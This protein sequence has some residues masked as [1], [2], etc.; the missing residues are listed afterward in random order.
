MPSDG[1][2]GEPLLAEDVLEV[3]KVIP[4]HVEGGPY[5]LVSEEAALRLLPA[6][7]SHVQCR[8][9]ARTRKP[10][11]GC[12]NGGVPDT[13]AAN[14]IDTLRVAEDGS[15]KTCFF[16]CD[17]VLHHPCDG[18]QVRAIQPAHIHHLQFPRIRNPVGVSSFDIK[19][20]RLT[21]FLTSRLFP[22]DGRE[23]AVEGGAFVLVR[24]LD[25]VRDS[26]GGYNAADLQ[27]R[28]QILLYRGCRL[29]PILLRSDL[30]FAPEGQAKEVRRRNIAKVLIHL[31]DLRGNRRVPV[32]QDE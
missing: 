2:A 16:D 26:R 1:S 28:L 3:Q 13:I 11:H 14:A 17:G 10:V 5:S 25:H 7:L 20:I 29:G 6:L 4:P 9:E 18:L 8:V 24:G 31:A 23:F 32:N 15:F 27:I 19:R 30:P 12:T 21:P 22:E